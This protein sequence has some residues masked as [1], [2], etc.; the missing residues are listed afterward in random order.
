MTPRFLV[1]CADARDAL[2]YGRNFLVHERR[3]A[4]NA[5][6]AK[7]ELHHHRGVHPMPE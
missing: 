3:A 7:Q 5:V 2:D 4:A 6:P 1:T